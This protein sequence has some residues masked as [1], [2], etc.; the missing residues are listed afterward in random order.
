M[1]KNKIIQDCRLHN[2]IISFL[3]LFKSNNINPYCNN[4]MDT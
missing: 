4:L 2:S 1:K 3:V